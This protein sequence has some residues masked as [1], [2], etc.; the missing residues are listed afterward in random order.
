[1]KTE[2]IKI[3][4]VLNSSGEMLDTLVEGNLE[5]DETIIF[6]HG[7]GVDKDDGDNIFPDIAKVLSK[8]FRCVRY[9]ASGCG[10]SDGKE[11][12]MNHQK[13]ADDFKSILDFTNKNFGEKI[14]VIGMSQGTIVLPLANSQIENFKPRKIILISPVDSDSVKGIE[15]KKRKILSRGGTF[16]EQGIS[17]SPR[18]SGKMEKIGS[19]YWKVLQNINTMDLMEKFS[20][21]SKIIMIRG[22][23]DEFIAKESVEDYKTI[24]NL[25]F[26]EIHG[27]HSFKLPEDRKVLLEKIKEIFE[28]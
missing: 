7:W 28:V 11:E 4:K 25:E 3:F 27:S 15:R 12:D 21:K 22:K 13:F 9:D 14:S 24:E 10:K 26:I 5:S 1:M 17:I 6:V 23:E 18:S 20:K 2:N 16:D 19:G 8:K